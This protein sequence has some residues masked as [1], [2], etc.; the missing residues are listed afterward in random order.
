[1]NNIFGDCCNCPAMIS[2]RGRLIMNYLSTKNINNNIMKL[3][4]LKN[5]NELRLFLQNN[6][7]SL[8]NLE[9][10]ALENKKCMDNNSNTFYL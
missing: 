2:D 5:N 9:K 6:G 10:L 8:N 1:M 3:N 7:N 4:N